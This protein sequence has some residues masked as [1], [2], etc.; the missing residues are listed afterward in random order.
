MRLQNEPMNVPEVLV[1]LVDAFVIMRRYNIAGKVKRVVGEVVETGGM[2][3]KIVLL[4]SLWS[5]DLSRAEFKESA[6]SSIYR[7]RLAQISGRSP[8]EIMDEIKVR[9][10]IIK[11]L[12]EKKIHDIK[13]VTDFCRKYSQNANAAIESLGLKKD[14]LS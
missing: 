2:E 8:R 6:V 12:V 5:Y 13:K 7:D 11:V 14:N 9:A 3:E 10:K 4:S 1:N